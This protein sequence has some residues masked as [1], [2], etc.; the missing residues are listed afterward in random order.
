[1]S[2]ARVFNTEPFGDLKALSDAL[3]LTV[4]GV[5]LE[6][7]PHF[8]QPEPINFLCQLDAHTTKV[9][10]AQ[11]VT[12]FLEHDAWEDNIIADP[13]NSI[14]HLKLADVSTKD[15]KD[16]ALVQ[17]QAVTL[18]DLYRKGKKRGLISARSSY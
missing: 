18:A 5:V 15:D 8:V 7:K 10:T 3:Y 4:I 2:G 17:K 6:G 16:L 9:M 14:S 1:M 13:V 12:W 11:Q